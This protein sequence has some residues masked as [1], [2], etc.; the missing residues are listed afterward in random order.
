VSNWEC[1]NRDSR[2]RRCTIQGCAL[3]FTRRVPNP[4]LHDAFPQ[5]EDGEPSHVQYVVTARGYK[6][7]LLA[8]QFLDDPIVVRLLKAGMPLLNP[9]AFRE[10]PCKSRPDCVLTQPVMRDARGVAHVTRDIQM[11]KE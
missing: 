11:V 9:E 5:E 4:L 2:A 8:L 6:S 3:G 1:E 10:G 7:L